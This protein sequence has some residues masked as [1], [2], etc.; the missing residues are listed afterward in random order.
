MPL[1]PPKP[2][3]APPAMIFADA[4]PLMLMLVDFE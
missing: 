4:L 2:P 3:P 1:A